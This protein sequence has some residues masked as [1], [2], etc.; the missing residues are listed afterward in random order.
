M[1]KKI[2]DHLRTLE[3]ERAEARAEGRRKLSIQNGSPETRRI[4]NKIY[5]QKEKLEQIEFEKR[6]S[7]RQIPNRMTHLKPWKD[8]TNGPVTG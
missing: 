5:Y 4:K 1:K 3:K 8:T 6:L 2:K 7:A